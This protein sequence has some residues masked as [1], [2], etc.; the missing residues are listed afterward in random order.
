[1]RPFPVAFLVLIALSVSSPS[2]RAAPGRGLAPSEIIQSLQRYEAAKD[3]SARFEA[4]KASC[5][6]S[7]ITQAKEQVDA[8]TF[9]RF[10]AMCAWLKGFAKSSLSA[11]RAFLESL[12]PD[13]V[14][15]IAAA[16]PKS[17][18]RYTSPPFFALLATPAC[19][20]KELTALAKAFDARFLR[21]KLEP[22]MAYGSYMLLTVD[23]PALCPPLLETLGKNAAGLKDPDGAR[24]WLERQVC[25][26]LENKSALIQADAKRMLGIGAIARTSGDVPAGKSARDH[27]LELARKFPNCM[28]AYNPQALATLAKKRA[29][30]P[31]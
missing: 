31:K 25:K 2:T 14:E 26:P 19:P 3:D 9:T 16:A 24:W 5:R 13:E 1:M 7:T 30:A 15:R 29:P 22:W 23:R 6:V 20:G 11:A 10:E 28:G 18:A 12:K 21:E 17:V 8:A 27:F 4:S